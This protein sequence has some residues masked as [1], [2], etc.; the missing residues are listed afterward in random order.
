M[1]CYDILDLHN[2][3]LCCPMLHCIMQLPKSNLFLTQI[4]MVVS[5]AGV[6]GACVMLPVVALY[7][8]MLHV[9][10][11]YVMMHYIVLHYMMW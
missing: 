10:V 4:V 2:I 11:H 6:P 7:Y 3:T 8:L 5:L 1:L 9:T